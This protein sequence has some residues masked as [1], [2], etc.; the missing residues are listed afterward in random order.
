MLVAKNVL[1]LLV[2]LGPV[3]LCKELELVWLDLFFCEVSEKLTSS[4][5]IL[6]KYT[7]FGNLFLK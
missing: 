2:E 4:F 7:P 5:I 3:V 6:D 1:Y